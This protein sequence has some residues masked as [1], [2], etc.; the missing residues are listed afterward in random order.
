MKVLTVQNIEGVA[1]SEKYFLALLPELIK[2]EVQCAVYCVYK[3]SNLKKAQVFFDMLDDA[4]IPY[5]LHEVNSYGSLTIP[6]KIAKTYR[7]ENFDIIHTHLI[8]ADFWGAMI[9]RLFL[10]RAKVIS[11]KHGYHE[12]TYV[13][14]CNLPEKL[15]RNLYSRLFKF[16]HKAFDKSYACSHGLVDFYERGGLIKKGSMDVIQ[17]GFDY[18]DIIE[19]NHEEYRNSNLQL[20]VVGRLIERKGHAILLRIM[21]DLIKKY[22]DINLNILGS[23]ELENDLKKLTKELNITK[24]VCFLGFKTEVANYLAA[25]TIAV[26]PSYSEGLPLVIFEAFNSKVP[27]VTFDA[28]GCNELVQHNET[29][30]IAKAFLAED[31]K[32]QIINMIEDPEMR[33]RFVDKAYSSLNNHFSLERMTHDTI[34]YYR[35]VL[36]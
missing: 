3:K 36:K 21:P 29:G 8:Y 10:K 16:T 30:L 23:G 17:H 2:N 12:S 32:N 33:G 35:S 24:N 5:F 20:I 4:N 1:G 26:V 27:V 34:N 7:K 14:F 18:P 19:F 25:S 15:P 11:T 28:I 13:E 22:P 31:L 6:R 9:K